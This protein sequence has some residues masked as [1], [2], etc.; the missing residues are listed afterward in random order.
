ML[1]YVV[2]FKHVFLDI[3]IILCFHDFPQLM[4]LRNKFVGVCYNPDFVSVTC[5]EM[6]AVFNWAV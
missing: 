3:Y 1:L 5:I 6:R 4:D 2:L